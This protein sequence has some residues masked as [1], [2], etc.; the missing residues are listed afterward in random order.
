MHNMYDINH[1]VVKMYLYLQCSV[2]WVSEI[3]NYKSTQKMQSLE[4]DFYLGT[5]CDFTV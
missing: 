3:L 4:K 1:F 2:K 5:P